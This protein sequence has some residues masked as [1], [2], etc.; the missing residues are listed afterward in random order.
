MSLDLPQL[1]PQVQQLSQSLSDRQAQQLTLLDEAI[2]SYEAMT[3]L[4]LAELEERVSL[5][6]SRWAGALAPAEGFDRPCAPPDLVA[7]LIVSGADGSQIYPDRHT[8]AAF[9]LV[10]IA[11][12]RLQ[13]DEPVAPETFTKTDLYFEDEQLHHDSGQPVGNAWVN[14]QR[15]VAEMGILSEVCPNVG[16][17]PGLALLD[18]SLLLWM[19]LQAHG[20]G[21][22]SL[23]RYLKNY[24]DSMARIRAAGCALAGIIDR[25]GSHNVLAL[26][27]LA[28]L[29]CTSLEA[30]GIPPVVFGGLSDRQLFFRLLP[31]GHRSP[32]FGLASPL[33]RDF[34]A[35]GQAIHFFYL[36]TTQGQILRVE[37]PGW[38]AESEP[39]LDRVH[40]GILREGRTTGGFPYALIRAHEL[41]VVT[42]AEG[43][44]LEDWIARAL[45]ERGLKPEAS[46]KSWT[47]TLT[48]ASGSLS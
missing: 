5:A 1:L 31:V 23:D 12:I 48:G 46:Q 32:C 28:M 17:R 35:A 26:T 45:A 3:N 19:M 38:V 47:K 34:Q 43:R 15:D 7:G 16:D 33:N 18:N 21:E 39:L 37:V 25:P 30:D 9:Y 13:H 36:H 24:L 4:P 40:A 20:A 11:A 8:A 44:M 29:P 22:K 14:L 41:A 2:H 27:Q 6:G 42:H 10:N